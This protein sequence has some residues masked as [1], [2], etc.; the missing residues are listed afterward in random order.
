MFN[1]ESQNGDKIL[2]V[3]RAGL[4]NLRKD[5]IEMGN[6]GMAAMADSD[7]NKVAGCRVVISNKIPGT[8]EPMFSSPVQSLPLSSVMLQN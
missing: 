5:I 8:R 7:V 1:D 4:K 6:A 2:L 3:N